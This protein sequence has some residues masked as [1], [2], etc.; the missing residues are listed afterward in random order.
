MSHIRLLN[1]IVFATYQR[2]PLLTK[3]VRER[4]Y[5]YLSGICN[6]IKC[7]LIIAGGIEDHVHMLADLH[8][9][10]SM[11]AFVR[12]NKANSSRFVHET[13][14]ALR[15]FAWQESYAAFSVSSSV[16]PKVRQYIENQESHHKRVSFIDELR[17]LYERHGLKFDPTDIER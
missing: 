6:N 4:L 2:Q 12:D 8:P 13:F 5:R 3:P 11:A 1:H 16:E 9:T 7:H 15:E 10:V 17:A 14:P